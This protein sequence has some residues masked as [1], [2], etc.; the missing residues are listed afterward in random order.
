MTLPENVVYNAHRY[1]PT[2][3][4]YLCVVCVTGSQ[5]KTRRLG[6]I[7]IGSN[8][9]TNWDCLMGGATVCS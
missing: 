5:G 2:L 6:W 1:L 4:W 3:S 9:S 8:I 7:R